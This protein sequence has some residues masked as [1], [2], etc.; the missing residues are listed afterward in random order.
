MHPCG[1]CPTCGVALPLGRSYVTCVRSAR[2]N[3]V[4]RP[5]K[6]T[7]CLARPQALIQRSGVVF[8]LPLYLFVFCAGHFRLEQYVNSLHLLERWPESKGMSNQPSRAPINKAFQIMG[9]FLVSG[10]CSLAHNARCKLCWVSHSPAGCVLIGTCTAAQ[11]IPLSGVAPSFKLS[12]PQQYVQANLSHLVG[13]NLELATSATTE[14][15]WQGSI[16]PRRNKDRAEYTLR[17]RSRN[18]AIQCCPLGLVLM[19]QPV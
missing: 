18:L 7:A 10:R 16:T 2:T 11:K 3:I 6:R 9:L 4:S 15:A 17:V 5:P 13:V 12:L 19:S 1:S 8:L 14:K